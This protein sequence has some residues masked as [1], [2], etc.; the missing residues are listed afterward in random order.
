MG[1]SDDGKESLHNT[2]SMKTNVIQNQSGSSESYLNH[3]SCPNPNIH[4]C[5]IQAID[6]FSSFRNDG[7][8]HVYLADFSFGT[9]TE[10]TNHP[11][12]I[13][14]LWVFVCLIEVLQQCTGNGNVFQVI[15]CCYPKLYFQ[16]IGLSRYMYAYLH[17]C[18][19]MNT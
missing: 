8:A 7:H 5:W 14:I 17:M 6:Q 18:M 19:C 15:W 9:F 16:N 11:E 2:I 13:S 4:F 3:T 12:K 10:T 1:N